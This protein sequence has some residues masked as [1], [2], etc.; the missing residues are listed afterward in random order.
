MRVQRA[1]RPHQPRLGRRQLAPAVNHLALGAHAL[2]HLGRATGA[3]NALSFNQTPAQASP[4]NRQRWVAAVL[5]MLD[6]LDVPVDVGL[7]AL[8]GFSPLAGRGQVRTVRLPRG[9]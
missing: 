9:A 5:L 2:H 6:A 4:Q 3:L 7:E 8:A 1:V